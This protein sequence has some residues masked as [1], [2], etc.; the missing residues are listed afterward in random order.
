MNS[1]LLQIDSPTPDFGVLGIFIAVLIVFY[2]VGF[3]ITILLMRWLLGT[4]KIIRQLNE[5]KAISIAQG[6][7]ISMIAQKNGISYEE[8][9]KAYNS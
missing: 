2:V 3:I 7:V 4:S 5:Q 8:I 1:V 9:K 6:K